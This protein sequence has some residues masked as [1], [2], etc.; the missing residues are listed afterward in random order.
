MLISY[1]ISLSENPE[2]YMIDYRYIDLP[3][4]IEEISGK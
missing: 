2:C 4:D 1:N 3:L